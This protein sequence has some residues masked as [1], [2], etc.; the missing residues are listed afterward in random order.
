HYVD[1]LE[2][3][4]LS[5]LS[6]D[7]RGSSHRNHRQAKK[8]VRNLRHA[9]KKLLAAAHHYV[10]ARD[11]LVRRFGGDCAAVTGPRQKYCVQWKKELNDKVAFYERHFLD[12]EG[13][14]GRS[15][16]K[17]VLV[18]PAL[19]K[20]YGAQ[21]LPGLTEAATDGDWKRFKRLE[22]R[23]A[24]LAESAAKSLFSEKRQKD[25]KH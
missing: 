10:F 13:L 6:E 5:K 1:D 4:V 25:G 12:E 20:G 7:D 16:F 11:A 24:K 22:R 19:W 2:Q 17:N 14:P 23:T 21:T 8:A 15:W 18:S 9:Q 3:V